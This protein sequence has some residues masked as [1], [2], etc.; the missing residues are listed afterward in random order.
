[1]RLADFFC[2]ALAAGLRWLFVNHNGM[3]GANLPDRRRGSPQMELALS[4]P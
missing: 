2:Y 3:D 1:M 4:Y